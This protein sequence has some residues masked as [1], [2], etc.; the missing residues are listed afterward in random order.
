[1]CLREACERQELVASCTGHV[2]S[3][4]LDVWCIKRSNSVQQ[5]LQKT[6]KQNPSLLL[7]IYG[8]GSGEISHSSNLQQGISGFLLVSVRELQAQR[9]KAHKIHIFSQDNLCH[10]QEPLIKRNQIQRRAV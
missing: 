5:K 1:M 10:V 8:V 3:L 7:L 6:T 2:S 9:L 4:Q